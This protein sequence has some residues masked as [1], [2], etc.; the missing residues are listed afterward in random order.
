MEKKK[1]Y[2]YDTT[3]RDGSQGEDVS[4]TLEDKIRIALKL[5]DLGIDFVEGGWPGSNP[6]DMY[7]FEEIKKYR[8]KN[9][10]ITA[11]GSTA[12][13]GNKVERDPNIQS[14]LK[15]GTEWITIFGKTW[16]FHVLEALRIRLDENL[17][18]IE[19]SVK[20]LVKSGKKVIY[21]AE[22]FFDGFQAN[23]DYAL[24]TI[25]AAING[26]ATFVCLC[27]TNGGTI[28]SKLSQ[29]IRTFTK[30]FKIPF[31]IHAHNDSELAVANSITAVE[32]GATQVQ[33]T[34]NGFGERC[35]NANLCSIIPNIQLKLKLQLLSDNNLKKL[36][37]VSRYIYEIANLPPAKNQ[38]FVGDSAFA[39]KGGVHVSAISKNAST[40]EH[41][42]PEQVGNRRRI[43]V[44]DLS[45]KSNVFFK[46]KE[47]NIDID[48]KS[49]VTTEILNTLKDME[50][51]GYQF[52]G[53]E[54]SF[55]LIMREAIGER[56]KYFELMGFRVI[57]EKRKEG[58]APVAEATVKIKVGGH[59][60][61]T[62]AE[63]N[64]PVNALDNAL[65]K[66]L[67]RFYP[68]LKDVKLYDYKVRVLT[69]EKGTGARVRVLIESG[70]KEEKWGTVGVSHNIIEASYQALVDSIEYKLY[71]SHRKS[72]K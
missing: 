31:G 52:E 69:S 23:P 15:A 27:D 56:R 37:E 14:L 5:D 1:I 29:I 65:R 7:F 68:D 67:E 39:H 4:F 21:D 60:E 41:I 10:N 26:G 63:G 40:Y 20:H 6:K 17:R 51:E 47:F 58:E 66:A 34:F 22:H 12:K 25:E 72:N 45:G 9:V 19:D 30:K 55:E 62:A 32:N 13:F 50:M 48:S 70:D 49:P 28:P 42:S 71:K 18:L 57:D 38:P 53:A 33:G 44:S 64:G 24:K 46:A 2:L 8:L 61:H 59:I 36:R 54:A 35:G 11:F 3:L 16:D 43:L